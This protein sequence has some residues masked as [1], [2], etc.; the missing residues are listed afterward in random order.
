MI[1]VK[2]CIKHNFEMQ[3]TNLN[4][5]FENFP[6]QRGRWGKMRVVNWPKWSKV[7]VFLF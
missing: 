4:I 6:I 3:F 1:L 5:R 7:K 2:I